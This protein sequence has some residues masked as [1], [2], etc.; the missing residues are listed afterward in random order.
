MTATLPPPPAPTLPK[1]PVDQPDVKGPSLPLLAGVVLAVA[2]TGFGLGRIGQEPAVVA[3]PPTAYVPIVKTGTFEDQR[4]LQAEAAMQHFAEVWL[5]PGSEPERRAALEPLVTPGSVERMTR[6]SEDLP[7]GVV[8]CPPEHMFMDA[9][10]A[11]YVTLLTTGE[12]VTVQ[13]RFTPQ[14]QFLVTEVSAT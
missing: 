6:Y 9:K 11:T 7:S 12:K 1:P 10:S 5:R 2:V 3:P 8:C 14:G 13:G 4:R